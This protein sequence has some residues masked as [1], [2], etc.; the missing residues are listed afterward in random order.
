MAWNPQHF[1]A[2]ITQAHQLAT[3]AQGFGLGHKR[4]AQQGK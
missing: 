1:K 4:S 2:A 3:A